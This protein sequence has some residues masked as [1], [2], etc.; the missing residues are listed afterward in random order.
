MSRFRFPALRALVIAFVAVSW[1]AQ[2]GWSA[3]G[4]W[5]QWRYDAARSADSPASLPEELRL[6]WVRQM[7][8]P[9]PAW[10]KY[11][12]TSFDASYEP[13]VLGGTMFVPSMV[14]D[15]VT[16]LD[17]DSGAVRWIFYA[18]GPVRFAPVAQEGRVY[19]VA[20]DGFL[21]CVDAEAGGLLWKF[22]GTPPGRKDRSVLG[23][24]RL[25]SL[26]PARGG[27]VLAE[28]RIY[29]ATGVFP[30]EGACVHCLD[31]ATGEVIWT[32]GD[33]DRIPR[34]LLDHSVVREG[35]LSPQGYLTLLGDK[36]FVPGGRAK[37][38]VLDARS[39]KLAPYSS[40]WGGREY[41]HKGGW[42]VAGGKD[43]YFASG[44]PFEL[45]TGKRLQIDPANAKELGEPRE[46]V[47][48]G[49]VAYFS[50]AI[51]KMLGYHPAGV[52][53]EAI[54][55]IDLA[56]KPLWTTVENPQKIRLETAV[57]EELWRLERPWKVHVK[58][59]PRLYAGAEGVVA[60]IELPSD[61]QAAKV[62]WQAKID[63]T[64]ARMV[65]GDG[66]LFVATEAG[67]LL[68]FAREAAQ[69]RR[70][71]WPQRRPAEVTGP[72]AQVARRIFDAT[73]VRSGY[74][75]LLG[76]GEGRLAE[77]LAGG[78]ELQVVVID[79]DAER[80]D[81]IR[82][83][84]GETGLY[85][86]R[87]SA[88]AGDPLEYPLPP[89]MAGLVVC[90]DRT[91]ARTAA[92]AKALRRVY[93]VLRPYGGTA[94][95]IAAAEALPAA[96]SGAG[97]ERAE[98]SRAGGLTLLK[99]QGDLPG[100]ADWTHERADAGA[101]LVSLDGRV[102]PPLGVLWFG[103][104]VD[105][106]FPEWDFT[107]SRPPTPLV[108]GGRMFF[109]TFPELHAVDVY[110]GRHL[111]TKTIPGLAPDAKRRNVNYVACKDRVYV[112]SGRSCYGL[113]PATGDVIIEIACPEPDASWGEVRASGD[114]LLG[115]AGR[116]LVSVD[117]HSGQKKWEHRGEHPIAAFAAGSDRVFFVDA[118]W[119]DRK[120]Q[121]VKPEG[122]VVALDVGTGEKLWTSEI[123]VDGPAN[124]PFHMAYSE[125][126][127]VLLAG[128]AKTSA[129]RSA[130]GSLL[131]S[132]D[133][134]EGVHLPLVHPEWLFTQVGMMI[135]LETGAR[136]ADGLWA[137]KRR[138]CTPVIGAANM[139]LIRD[140][141]ASY[142]DFKEGATTVFRGIR[143][144]CTNNLIAADGLLSAPN[145]AH[146]CSC[147][148]SVYTSLAFAP[149]ADIEE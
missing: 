118:V 146:G 75:V 57:Y 59:G 96:V 61:G 129:L 45:A 39:G 24:D 102:K 95:F 99:R 116:L 93:R 74:C 44:D 132:A 117:R 89:Y 72:D 85:G 65:C 33:L 149:L 42:Y 66:K 111:W 125:P 19:F 139:I 55:A 32:N 47:L 30:F 124:V 67:R 56:S 7:S 121:V 147:N 62:S 71:R 148:Y 68:A 2:S 141:F 16:A 103:G 27:P 101:S 119:G 26:Y 122:R 40:D 28:G 104:A 120:G 17:T 38:A 92:D 109:Q 53:Y 94:C 11:L 70:H 108:A 87:V 41:L 50:L 134:L 15:S 43:Y 12:R 138:G 100:A 14:T 127:G 128:R 144:G 34:A 131:W 25:I 145:F 82:R 48:A 76:A 21:Y 10:P 3:A 49:N 9:E 8:L 137:A 51:N 80:V 143:V 110:T 54:A 114:S 106:L 78:S 63:G 31:A 13:V 22:H 112:A 64:P 126:G 52:G 81:A 90:D 86:T 1:T 58:A 133:G 37:A 60:A 140:A 23:N 91:A 135:D 113:D 115:I 97:L 77:A 5:P 73:D 4:D 29:F 88:Y 136:T 105:M 6:A 130:D 83:Q 20:D 46:P 79:A 69:V 123:D 36:L 18:G 142:Y 84:L 107:H 35:G 98:V